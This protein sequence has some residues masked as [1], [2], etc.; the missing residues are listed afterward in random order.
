MR[1]IAQSIVKT[2]TQHWNYSEIRICCSRRGITK[3]LSCIPKRV[4]FLTII[5]YSWHPSSSH[6]CRYM[7]FLADY[8]PLVQFSYQNVFGVRVTSGEEIRIFRKP[9]Q[10]TGCCAIYTFN[11]PKVKSKKKF[12]WRL[13]V[14]P[15]K[16]KWLIQYLES[17]LL[18]FSSEALEI[19]IYLGCFYA[20]ATQHT[21]TYNWRRSEVAA[22]SSLGR[23]FCLLA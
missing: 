18:F 4:S 23:V 14:S 17:H 5:P 16:W 10:F 22:F 13:K 19:V 9:F 11:A 2:E 15:F 8:V 12:V 1:L 6:T 20:D 3:T 21:T 7:L